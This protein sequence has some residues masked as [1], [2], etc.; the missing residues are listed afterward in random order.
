MKKLSTQRPKL[1]LSDLY[2][3]DVVYSSRPSYISNPWLEPE[4]HQSNFLTGR[5]LII[6]DQMPV[7]VHKA[8][9]TKKLEILFEMIGKPMPTNIYNFDNQASYE[10]IIRKLAKQDNKRIYFQYI[11]S[12]S[13]L[14]KEYYAMD[15][16]IFVALNN[17]AR[18]PEWTNQKYLPAREVVKIEDFEDAIADWEFPFVLKP[19]DDL[20]TA[21]GYGVMICYDEA[22]LI[23]A[24]SR[25][26]QARAETDTII[27]EQKI[28]EIAN[29]CVQFACKKDGEIH[30]IGTSEQIT[31]KYGHNSGNQN[32]QDVP[33]SVIQAGKEIMEIG[34][35][36]GYFGI[37]GFD[38]LLDKHGDIFAIDLNFRQNGST[39]MLLLD[40]LMQSGYQKFYSYIAPNDNEHFFQTIIKYVNMGCLFPLSYYDGDWYKN[41]NVPSRFACIWHGQSQEHIEKLEQQFLEE[42]KI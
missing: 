30:Y 17:K 36:K 33:E 10:Q 32:V 14:E 3:D 15:K 16:D 25:I 38:L 12:E 5:E 19:G 6:A 24:K 42:L 11:H 9:A 18:I 40:P 39:S 22:D 26:E 35:A 34:V 7:I 31:D 29:Y 20:P 13:I 23:K 41:E 1:T 8:S 2:N 37:A 4:E 21:G 28:Q 27:I